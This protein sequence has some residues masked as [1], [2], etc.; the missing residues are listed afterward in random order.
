MMYAT[1]NR[2]AHKTIRM[3]FCEAQ[4][5]D[6]VIT[7]DLSQT[8]A[9]KLCDTLTGLLQDMITEDER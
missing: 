5:E 9:E 8:Q 4:D 3:I 6:M 1:V 2:G 7:L